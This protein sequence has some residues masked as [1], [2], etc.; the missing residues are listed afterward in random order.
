MDVNSIFHVSYNYFSASVV[1][2]ED[3]KRAKDKP[4]DEFTVSVNG[5]SVDDTEICIELNSA[6]CD[7]KPVSILM[8]DQDAIAFAKAIL[9]IASLRR[10]Y[11]RAQEA[12][13]AKL[14]GGTVRKENGARD[15]TIDSRGAGFGP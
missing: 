5:Q 4:L 15:G 8:E 13:E 11:Y 1:I 6:Y 12:E 2:P 3:M 10:E 7:T 14:R 9:H